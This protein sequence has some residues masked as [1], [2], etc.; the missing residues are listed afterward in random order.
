MVSDT[1]SSQMY[2][3]YSK[4]S[5][6]DC[7]LQNN[8]QH[9][10]ISH[11]SHLLRITSKIKKKMLFLTRAKKYI[12]CHAIEYSNKV[13]HPLILRWIVWWTI[14]SF[15]KGRWCDTRIWHLSLVQQPAIF[16]L[17]VHNSCISTKKAL[18]TMLA[19][20]WLID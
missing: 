15:L 7:S 2:D 4:L 8:L 1:H 3:P 13:Y 11:T 19:N 18:D 17:T 6:G 14:M 16:I 10:T 5:N 12:K 20:Y 9:Q